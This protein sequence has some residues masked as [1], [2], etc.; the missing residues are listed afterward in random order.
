VTQSGGVPDIAN[1]APSVAGPSMPLEPALAAPLPHFACPL[2]GG[3]NGCMPAQSG[4][5][6]T[7][8]WCATAR[9]DPPALARAAA[10]RVGPA[11]ICRRCA[12]V[13]AACGTL[14]VSDRSVS[15]RSDA[16]ASGP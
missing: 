9:F 15:D 13:D 12:G 3:P 7:P 1:D 11:C 14:A 16:R 5:F 2:C 10:A 8:C 4:S 6:S